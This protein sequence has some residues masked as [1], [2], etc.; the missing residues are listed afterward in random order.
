MQ[1]E[2][3][4]VD[5]PKRKRRWFQFS[6]RS[7]MI[8][9]TLAA[10]LCGWLAMRIERAKQQH[11]AVS[12]FLRSH[13][14]L[15]YDY[16]YDAQGNFLPNATPPALQWLR[17][18]T[19][20]DLLSSVKS[21]RFFHADT[22][23]D[24]ELFAGMTQAESVLLSGPEVTDA[25]LAH[26]RGMTQLKDLSLESA[27]VTDAGLAQLKGL[28]QLT[29]LTIFFPPHG[30]NPVEPWRSDN[31]QVADAGVQYLQEM[32][33][34]R[35]LVLSYTHVTDAD[36]DRLKGMTQLEYLGLAGTQVTDAGV[37][38]LQA[39]LPKCGIYR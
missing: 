12:A 14:E 25:C 6:L 29:Q 21:I 15:T 36:L 17:E 22:N 28:N 5:P 2:S 35:L 26:L 18:L 37:A 33:Q 1:T 11:E 24:L 13:G 4:K 39:S 8:F 19:T 7:L 3:P 34:L 38:K 9:M 30:G 16:Q 32:T 27:A 23:V 10:G 31:T 20:V